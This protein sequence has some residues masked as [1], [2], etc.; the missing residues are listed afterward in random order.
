MDD[1]ERRVARAAQRLRAVRAQQRMPLTVLGARTG[2]SVSTLSR[3][4]TGH[5]RLTIE[6]LMRIAD[7]LRVPVDEMLREEPSGAGTTP[8]S[9][10]DPSMRALNP[11]S[12]D[13]RAFVQVVAP[14]DPDRVLPPSVHDGYEWMYVLRGRVLLHLG[15]EVVD[16]APGEVAEFDTRIPH[17]VRN[18]GPAS[19][20]LLHLFG[21]QGERAHVRV[22]TSRR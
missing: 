6:L 10:R 16:L 11:R 1:I 15:D 20:E 22:T 2:I 18:P 13:L 21:P 5:R 3:V 9:R 8:G 14:T 4:E 19:A 12:G 7:G 17:K